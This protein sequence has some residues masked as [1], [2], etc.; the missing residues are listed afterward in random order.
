M[1]A[2]AVSGEESA[3][4]QKSQTAHYSVVDTFAAFMTTNFFFYF[5]EHF[6]FALFSCRNY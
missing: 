6:N 1:F 5:F 4:C 3:D 2:T